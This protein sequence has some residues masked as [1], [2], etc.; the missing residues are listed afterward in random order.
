MNYRKIALKTLT[1]FIEK[2]P[3]LTIGQILYSI[4]RPNNSGAQTIGELKSISE[5]DM[6]TAIE[7]AKQT[8]E[9]S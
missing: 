8:E 4:V 7:K 3:D 2:N 5:E 6:Y 9:D 1:E